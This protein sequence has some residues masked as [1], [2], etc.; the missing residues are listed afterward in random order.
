M[1]YLVRHGETAWSLTGQHTG[2]TDLSLTENGRQQAKALKSSLE[3]LSFSEVW[4]S[5]LKRARETCQLAGFSERAEIM[6]ELTEWNY[7]SYEGLTRA[8]IIKKE[9]SWNI[10]E[11]G[12]PS[13]ESP[14]DIQA[15]AARVIARL[16]QA[17]GHVLIFSSAHILRSI[18]SCYVSQTPDFGRYLLLNPASISILDYEHET[19]VIKLW[20][21]TSSH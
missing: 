4:C 8:E 10:F 19:P 6:P 7:G 11:H 13:G 21:L 17:I 2:L 12:A 20:N 3:K 9:P 1:F 18:A 5:P 15:R 14:A 16:H